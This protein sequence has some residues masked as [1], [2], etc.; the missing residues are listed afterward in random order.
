[1]V[2]GR[3]VVTGHCVEQHCL[4]SKDFLSDSRS[5]IRDWSQPIVK[6]DA[7]SECEAFVSV[8]PIAVVTGLCCNAASPKDLQVFSPSSQPIVKQKKPGMSAVV[9]ITQESERS[10]Y[11]FVL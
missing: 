5:Q 6:E 9:P 1:M 4:C 2:V 11:R 3:E 7:S 10:C 8:V